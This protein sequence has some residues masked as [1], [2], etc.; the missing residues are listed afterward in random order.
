M[1]Q[2]HL[3]VRERRGEQWVCRLTD[4]GRLAA[5]G[6]RDAPARWARRW[7]G[8]WRQLLFDLPVGNKSARLRLWR[9]LRDNGFG[10]LQQS[11]WIHPDPVAEVTEALRGFRDDV[12][13]L[14]LMEAT[15]C[16]GY[17]NEAVVNGAWDFA[18]INNRYAAHHAI[19]GLSVRAE[20]RL[21]GSPESLGDWLR[22]ERLAWRHA[23]DM[24]PLLPR[25]LWPKG[26]AGERAWQTRLQTFQSLSKLFQ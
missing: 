24:D 19:V 21:A 22:R 25:D 1:Q 12:E 18:E 11:V 16:A 5:L 14:I 10:Y 13:S 2:R 15:C 4:M 23:L 7:D 20:E 9:W 6:G 3:L 17:S 26:Y 8:R